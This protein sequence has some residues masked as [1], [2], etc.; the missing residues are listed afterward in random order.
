MMGWWLA[1]IVDDV[2]LDGGM[3]DTVSVL[4]RGRMY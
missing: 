3:A 4:V 1:G 2:V